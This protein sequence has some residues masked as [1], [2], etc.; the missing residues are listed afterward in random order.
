MFCTRCGKQNPGNNKFCSACGAILRAVT[1]SSD[2]DIAPHPGKN[3]VVVGVLLLLGISL[4]IVIPLIHRQPL[5]ES[6]TT[7][8]LTQP[9]PHAPAYQEPATPEVLNNLDRSSVK[10]FLEKTHKHIITTLPSYWGF[11]YS[12]PSVIDCFIQQGL[13]TE[14]PWKER[15]LVEGVSFTNIGR[16]FVLETVSEPGTDFTHYIVQYAAISVLEVTGISEGIMPLTGQKMATVK[17][18]YRIN[19]LTPF[20]QC[21]DD[22]K[23]L[24]LGPAN[25]VIETSIGPAFILYDDGWRPH[26]MWSHCAQPPVITPNYPFYPA[27]KPPADSAQAINLIHNRSGITSSPPTDNKPVTSVKGT[28]DRAITALLLASSA[29]LKY[30]WY[31][32][33]FL[34]DKPKQTSAFF[35]LYDDGWRYYQAPLDSFKSYQ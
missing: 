10:A 19:L 3:F 28:L 17:F 32:M 13:I 20:G 22:P 5:S 8:E 2:Q 34:W 23:H 16:N 21:E 31:D 4:I 1:T 14:V 18:K 26:N 6:A 24:L 11:P 33:R 27:C 9:S 30:A 25:T 12:R 29:D 7:P 35:S 15:L